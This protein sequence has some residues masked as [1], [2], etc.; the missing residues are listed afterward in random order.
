M[1][2]PTEDTWPEYGKGILAR[3]SPKV[4]IPFVVALVGLLI[5]GFANEFDT[6]SI[7][8]LV[9]AFVTG[10][11][12]LVSPAAIGTQ[13]TSVSQREVATVLDAKARSRTAR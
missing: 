6:A 2:A 10:V 11:L 9:T 13:S 4:V 12:G 5:Y 3:L 1:S 7:V 8:G